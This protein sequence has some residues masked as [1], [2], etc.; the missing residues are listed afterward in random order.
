[1]AVWFGT[2]IR[3]I[4]IRRAA[5]QK[6]AQSVLTHAGHPHGDLSLTLVGKTRMQTLNRQY[7][8]KDYPTDVLAFPMAEVHN[9]CTPLLGDV[10]ICL[11]IAISQADHFGNSPN[12]EIVRHL[13]HGILHLLGYDHERSLREARRMQKK[14]QTIFEHLHPIPRLIR[15]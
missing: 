7:R 1:M 8:K 11:P 12:E 9:S 14:E 10:I 3:S 4:H 6:I 15:S 13:I 5:I 2:S